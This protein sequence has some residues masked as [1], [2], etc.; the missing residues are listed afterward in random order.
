MWVRWG[1]VVWDW[2]RR[3]WWGG[4]V[5]WKESGVGWGGV[6]LWG[7]GKWGY[8]GEQ[9]C[10]GAGG[11]VVVGRYWLCGVGCRRGGIGEIQTY[12]FASVTVS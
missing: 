5:W 7:I 4:V 2:G 9:H 12:L 10:G 1:G 6:G 11:G 3:A 8:V